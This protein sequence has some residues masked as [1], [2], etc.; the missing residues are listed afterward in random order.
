M[1]T[2]THARTD[3]L[4]GDALRAVL[5]HPR[6]KRGLTELKLINKLLHETASVHATNMQSDCRYPRGPWQIS[7]GKADYEARK[8]D[9]AAGYPLRALGLKPTEYAEARLKIVPLHQLRVSEPGIAKVGSWWV[10][11]WQDASLDRSYYA[12]AWHPSHG[13]KAMVKERAVRIRRWNPST[14]A[15]EIKDVAVERWGRNV[16]MNAVVQSGIVVPATCRSSKL[17]KIQGHPVYGVERISTASICT[18]PAT[19]T[20]EVVSVYIRT[21]ELDSQ[22]LI[23]PVDYAVVGDEVMARGA[24]RLDAIRNYAIARDTKAAM[25]GYTGPVVSMATARKLKF[26]KS[27]VLAFCE[28]AGFDPA[29]KY[30]LQL[31]L[32]R[33]AEFPDAHRYYIGYLLQLADLF[34]VKHKVFDNV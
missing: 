8:H 28:K 25:K 12:R 29:G 20:E 24:T 32:D 30:P 19:W 26:C 2:L 15:I 1:F 18:N 14:K 13:P 10:W 21:L 31:F 34:G 9:A 3:T 27:G 11:P 23:P 6:G 33:L 5:N 22:P 7:A 17:R 4:L 16:I